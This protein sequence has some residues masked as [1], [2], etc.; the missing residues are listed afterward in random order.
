[1]DGA[2]GLYHGSAPRGEQLDGVFEEPLE[3]VIVHVEVVS[4][5]ALL[6][7]GFH[8]PRG[9]WKLQVHGL[10]VCQQQ[11]DLILIVCGVE[12]IA[13]HVV[14]ERQLFLAHILILFAVGLRLFVGVVWYVR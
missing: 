5:D 14:V 13:H 8:A 9:E 1:M 11:R 10:I 7:S 3:A 6:V 12:V 4:G 2:V